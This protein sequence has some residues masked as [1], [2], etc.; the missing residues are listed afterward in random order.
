MHNYAFS[1]SLDTF[2]ILYFSAKDSEQLLHWYKAAESR[3][4]TYWHNAFPLSNN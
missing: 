2:A 3:A 4:K 1:L